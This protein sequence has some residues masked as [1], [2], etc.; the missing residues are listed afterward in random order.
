M[1]RHK[2]QKQGKH[3]AKPKKK[4]GFFARLKRFMLIV[5]AIL[6]VLF[7]VGTFLESSNFFNSTGGKVTSFGIRHGT[8]AA[9][10]MLPPW[11]TIPAG[12]ML[13]YLWYKHKLTMSIIYGIVVG[14]WL[15][16][17]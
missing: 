5:A 12:I 17:L 4:Q 13:V 11:I 6:F 8:S 10:G 16:M 7:M 1:S 3:T 15:G 9:Y 2:Q 14:I